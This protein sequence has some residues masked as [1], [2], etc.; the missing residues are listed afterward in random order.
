MHI[1]KETMKHILKL[2]TAMLLVLPAV[3]PAADTPATKPNI[4]V[5]Y[6]DDQGYADL[7][8]QG[9]VNDIRTPNLDRMA[10]EGVRCT[11]GY[12]TAPQCTPSRAGLLAGRYQQRF[13]LDENG[14]GTPPPEIELLPSRLRRAGYRTC[15]V[16]KWDMGPPS[17]RGLTDYFCGNMNH[18]QAN[19]DPAGQP[20]KAGGQQ[21]RVPGYR[22][23][24]Q[25]DA[26]CQFLREHHRE[27][28]F[29]YLAYFAPHVPLE[30]PE[31]YLLRFPGPMPE[32]RRL[33][34]AMMSAVDDGVG[35]VLGLLGEFGIDERT[36]IFFSS[37]N[38]A[39]LKLSKP[40]E[41]VL[42]PDAGWDGSLN[43]PWIGEKG[44]L[45]EAGIR[46]PFLVR[47]KGILP[48]GKVYDEPV[49]TLDIAATVLPAAGLPVA[50]ELDGVD[51]LPHLK[52]ESVKAP[53][54][55]LFWRFWQQAAV[56]SGRWKYLCLSDEREFLFDLLADAHERK[57]VL[58]AHAETAAQMKKRL[59]AWAGE[60]KT[61]GL[62]AGPIRGG[63]TKWYEYHPV[64]QP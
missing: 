64:G 53:H 20:L 10:R 23:D 33:G 55:F 26:A 32:R 17:E 44:M 5:I 39:P 34:L 41:P 7:G 42:G 25:T 59:V 22:V 8:C 46:V 21:I 58:P 29:L 12:V 24:I 45:T 63:E 47:W 40:D 18:Y 16:G 9:A 57:N 51:L 50:P 56:R 62:P 43:D 1:Q 38:G 19:F 61:P 36:L 54:E 3:L 48:A 31:K 52:G 60:L 49:S 15:A 13:G 28:F 11:A 37:D 30:A 2:L 6:T 27:P 4:I 35:R 14:T